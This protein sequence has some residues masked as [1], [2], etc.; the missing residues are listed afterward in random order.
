MLLKFLPQETPSQN[1]FL[2]KS[3]SGEYV[4]MLSRCFIREKVCLVLHLYR[5]EYL[6][7]EE[8]C[9]GIT[10]LADPL[11]DDVNATLPL[12]V[13]TISFNS[14][15]YTTTQGQIIAPYSKAAG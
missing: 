1:P 6:P 10:Y 4:S 8:E 13:H 12:E 9:L 2:M 14:D 7:V 11:C 5:L 15:Y 3:N